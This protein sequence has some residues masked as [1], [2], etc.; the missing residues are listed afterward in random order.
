MGETG[1]GG[2]LSKRVKPGRARRMGEILG[3][4]AWAE[5]AKVGETGVGITSWM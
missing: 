1:I 2:E 5:S 4:G 3:L